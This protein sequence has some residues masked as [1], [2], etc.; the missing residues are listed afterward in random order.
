LVATFYAYIDEAGDEGLPRPY[1]DVTLYRDRSRGDQ[2]GMSPFFSLTAAI[3]EDTKR[4]ATQKII[5]EMANRLYPTV[6]DKVLHWRDLNWERKE[7]AAKIVSGLDFCW[8]TIVAYKPGLKQALPPPRMYNFCTRMLLERLC[9]HVD[10]LGGELKPVFSSRSRTDYVKLQD[11]VSREVRVYGKEKCLLPLQTDQHTNERLLQLADICAG[12]VEN[13]LEVN[14]YGNLQTIFLRHT[15]KRLRR[16]PGGK[17][18]GYG[19]KIYPKEDGTNYG[20]P[21]RWI[22][23][24][25]KR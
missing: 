4:S 2:G 14:P 20:P 1:T 16:G 18:W 21:T 12:T 6:A 24:V 3:V 19:F 5:R 22:E 25:R 13:A 7:Q 23:A 17:V 11:Y 15:G 10:D 9:Y 8:L